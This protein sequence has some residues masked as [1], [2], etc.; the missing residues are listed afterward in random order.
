MGQ[1]AEA[2][3]QDQFVHIHLLYWMCHL[4][5]TFLQQLRVWKIKESTEATSKGTNINKRLKAWETN[6]PITIG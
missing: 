1:Y 6:K 4:Y 3:L 5:T 2:V